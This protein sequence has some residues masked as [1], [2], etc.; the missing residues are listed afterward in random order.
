MSFCRDSL[1]ESTLHQLAQ[2]ESPLG[3]LTLIAHDDALAAIQFDFPLS[4]EKRS[5]PSSQ[6]LKT[7][8]SQLDDYFQGTRMVFEIPLLLRGTNFQ[9]A[10]WKNLLQI[11]F[12]TTQSYREQA[13]TL[14]DARKA[15]AAAMAIKKNPIAIVIGCHRVIA[16]S[17]DIGGYFGDSKLGRE[18]KKWLLDWEKKVLAS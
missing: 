3:P 7:A 16:K 17:G 8:V 5:A 10:A 15:R 9:K 18:R 2:Y 11:P 14:G 13:T 4:I 1:T 12:G 6:L